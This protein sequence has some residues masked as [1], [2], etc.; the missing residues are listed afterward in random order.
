MFKIGDF[1]RLTQISVRMLRH[2]DETG[3]LKPQAVDTSTGYRY[4]GADQLLAANRI[5]VL[6]ELGFTLAEMKGLM[7]RE[8]DTQQLR[9]LLTNRRREITETV[10]HEQQRLWR[11][12]SLIRLI[13]KE[14]SGMHYDIVIKNIPAYTVLSLRDIIPAYNAEGMLWQE[15]QGFAA[16]HNLK[17]AGISYAI[18]HD[19]GYKEADVDV[20]VTMMTGDDTEIEEQGRVKVKTLEAVPEMAVIFHQGPFEEIRAAYHALG[21]WM[22]ANDYEMNG[23]TRAIYHKGPWCEQDPAGYLTEIQAPVVKR[24]K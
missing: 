6:K 23:P 4:Y 19:T 18:Y 15:L 3:L 10:R 21:V 8:L 9:S 2:Y 13:D 7:V 11:V 20:E 1:S 16:R 12:D 17:C 22:S 5:Q 14:D 24:S